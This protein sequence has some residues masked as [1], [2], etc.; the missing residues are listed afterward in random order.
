MKQLLLFMTVFILVCPNSYSQQTCDVKLKDI[1][2]VYTG[3]CIN[4]KA[5]GKGKSVGTDE[6]EGDFKDGYP[7]GKGMYTWKDGHYFI[8]VFKKGN[9][10]GRGEMYYESSKGD[11]SVI[12]GFWKKDKYIGEYESQFVI[13]SQTARIGRIDCHFVDKKSKNITIEVHQTRAGIAAITDITPI[14]GSFYNKKTQMLT[15]SSVTYINDITFPFRALFNISSGDVA[16]ITFY[17][18]GEYAVT[19][20]IN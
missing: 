17:E 16:E 15:N 20:N 5:N 6:Y 9:K 10:E 19:I 1:Q 14:T 2:G 11:D 3:N 8:G 7:E 18:T 13:I 4:D 12:T